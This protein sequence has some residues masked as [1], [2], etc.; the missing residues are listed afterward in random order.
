M[1]ALAGFGSV[2]FA[3][4]HGAPPG[5]AAEPVDWRTAEAGFL[6]RQ[7]QLTFAGQFVK[8]GES[9]FS[10]D[11]QRVIFQAVEVPAAGA[12]PEEFYAMFV[13]DLVAAPAEEIASGSPP[14]RLDGIRRV[15]PAGSANTCGWFHPTDPDRI[16][17]ASTIGPPTASEPPG[18]Q[19]GTSRYRWSFPPET[20]IVEANLRTLP[21]V[22][23]RS[24]GATTAAADVPAGALRVLAGDGSAYVAEGSLSPDGRSLLFCSLDSNQGDLVVLDL[25]TGVVTP[26]ISAPG[27]D[28]GPFFSPQGD[29]ICYRSDRAG[30]NLLQLYVADL[31]RGA[32][33]RIEGAGPEYVV[34]ANNDVNWCPYWHPGGAHLAYAT[35]AIG[36]RNYEVFLTDAKSDDAMSP[37]QRRYG[38]NPRRITHADGADVL[39][40]FDASGRLMMWTS[41]RHPDRS[42]QL[43]IADFVMPLAPQRADPAVRPGPAAGAAAG[44]Q[45]GGAAQPGGGSRQ[46]GTTGTGG[47]SQPGGAAR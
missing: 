16:I 33:G 13:A 44:A 2:A 8:A 6:D 28:G 41:Q 17:F 47:V 3:Q 23:L 21:V 1:L 38:T 18:Y 15:S 40:A 9:Y 20:R 39:P 45:T 46:G 26:L 42:S 37:P 14:W 7:T 36:H 31:Q 22:P 10:P 25:P 11:G 35:S 43:W 30:N 34:T 32:D 27:Y 19:R 29:R 24:H 5:G 12:E 4:G